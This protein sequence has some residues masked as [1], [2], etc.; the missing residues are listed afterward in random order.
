[1]H[2]DTAYEC[3]NKNQEFYVNS[4]SVSAKAAESFE[5]WRQV[6]AVWIKDTTPNPWQMYNQIMVDFKKKLTYIPSNLIPAFAVEGGALL[7]DKKDRLF[8]LKE[9]GIKF[10]SLTWNGENLLAGGCQSEKCLTDFGKE[11]ITLMNSLKIG[12]DLSHLNQKSFYLAVERAGFPLATHSNCRALCDNKRNLTDNQISLI[13]EKGGIIG[14]CFYPSFLSGNVFDAIYENIFYLC[15]KGYENNIAIGSDFDGGK[16]DLSLC[17]PQQIPLLYAFLSKKGLEEALLNK[18]FFDN[19]D[20]FI[21][22]L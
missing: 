13:A 17:R 1:M 18:I 15:D 14:L 5:I 4:L 8:T 20:N 12:C 9:D 3:Y 16:M 2:C 22:K 6:F 21:A 7:E 19:A 11:V 10:L